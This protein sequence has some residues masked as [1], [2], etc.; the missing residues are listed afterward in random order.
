MLNS[1]L[2]VNDG[3]TT[4]LRVED[5]NRLAGVKILAARRRGPGSLRPRHPGSK[6]PRRQAGGWLL[7]HRHCRPSVVRERKLAVSC[8]S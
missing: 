7:R 2:A 5:V 6:S 1:K 8:G 3:V 4:A